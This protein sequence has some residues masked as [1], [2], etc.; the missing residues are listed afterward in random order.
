MNPHDDFERIQRLIK[1]KG[2][3]FKIGFSGDLFRL[4][5]INYARAADITSGE[6]AYLHGGRYNFPGTHK[7]TYL[8]L[9]LA[10]AFEEANAYFTYAGIPLAKALPRVEIAVGVTLSK[11]LDLRDGKLRKVLQISEKRLVEEDWRTAQDAGNEALTQALGR[12]AFEL[13]FEGL[14][15][16]SAA[17]RTGGNLCVFPGNKL[18]KSRLRVL[19]AKSLPK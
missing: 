16:P 18:K 11:V 15:F 7:T 12:A 4:V 6:G 17:K 10:A 9:D 1:K 3:A 2:A 13:G 19:N 14:L 5:G 8:S